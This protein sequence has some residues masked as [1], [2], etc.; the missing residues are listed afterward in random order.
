M[1]RPLPIRYTAIGDSITVGIGALFNYGYAYQYRD[2]IKQDLKTRVSFHNLGKVG[3][4]SQKLLHALKNNTTFSKSIR[5]ANII[6]CSIGGNDL[7]QAWRIYEKTGD[8]KILHLAF[9]NFR[10]HFLSIDQNIKKI[11]GSS[12]TPY[13]VC[14]IEIYNPLPTLTLARKW[15]QKFN[16]VLYEVADFHIKIAPVYAAF[17][18]HE[19]RLLFVDGKHPNHKGHQIIAKTIRNLNYGLFM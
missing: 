14:Y 12:P 5:T 18:Y 3:W 17:L 7:I 15:V 6:T 8:K 10:H 16:Q 19:H 4:T 13:I 1:T 2:S 11:K 9:Q